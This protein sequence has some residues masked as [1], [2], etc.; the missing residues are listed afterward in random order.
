MRRRTLLVVLAVVV[1]AGVVVLWPGGGRV[2]QANA[3]R[4]R[5]GMSFSE[6]KAILGITRA[7]VEASLGPPGDHT[8]GPTRPTGG[9]HACGWLCTRG[10]GV[11]LAYESVAQWLTDDGSIVVAFDAKGRVDSW[12]W[13]PTQRVEQGPLDNLLWRAKR[14]WHRWFP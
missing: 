9:G 5:R 12:E 7:E 1:A 8:T 11:G 10:P 14:Q 3:I 13:N 4:I 6:V 2:T